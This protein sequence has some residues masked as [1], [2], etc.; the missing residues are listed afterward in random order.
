M[1]QRRTSYRRLLGALLWVA[2]LIAAVCSRSYGFD[3]QETHP[4][5][6]ELA[7]KASTLDASLT[8]V[9]GIADGKDALLQPASGLPRSILGWLQDGST[10]E[11]DPICRAS[12]HFHNPHQSFPQAAVTDEAI[13]GLWC[14]G[15]SENEHLFSN[16]TWGTGFTAPQTPG[17]ESTE[18]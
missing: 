10:R 7:V 16:V 13:V 18:F 2:I 9:L 11:D 3:D 1:D 14:W 6:T 17:T 8:T 12:N 5:M 15:T 4:R